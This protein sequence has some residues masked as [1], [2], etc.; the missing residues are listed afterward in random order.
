MEEKSRAHQVGNR[1]YQRQSSWR[2]SLLQWGDT[3]REQ[4]PLQT[5]GGAVE[6]TR[7][8]VFSRVGILKSQKSLLPL[9]YGW[10]VWRKLGRLIGPNCYV[11]MSWGLE[12]VEPFISRGPAAGWKSPQVLNW[13]ASI[14][15]Q[16]REEASRSPSP[17]LS[18]CL[19]AG[20]SSLDKHWD[21]VPMREAGF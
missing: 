10:S 11:N 2:K 9:I 6:A 19:P 13:Q 17:C 14:L 3:C 8:R 16:E 1:K 20:L 7:S 4:D 21:A 18:V 5:T 12:L 15:G